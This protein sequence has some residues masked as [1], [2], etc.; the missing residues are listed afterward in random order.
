MKPA[1]FLYSRPDSIEVALERLRANDGA[2]LL[3]GGQSLVPMLNLRLATPNE[4]VD[5]GGI[6]ELRQLTVTE[7]AVLTGAMTTQRTV[8]RSAA[9]HERVPL[10][11]DALKH[12][13]HA[14]T[15]NRGTVGGSI[16]H[17]DPSAEIGTAL[18]ALDG[19]L[20]VCSAERGERWVPAEEL[21]FTYFTTTV[22][23][24]ELTIEVEFPVSPAGAGHAFVEVTRRAGDFALASA[25]VQLMLSGTVIADIRIAVGGAASTP[26]RAR[27]AEAALVG[28]ELEDVAALR[29]AAK[30]PP[31]AVRF[32]RDVHA[33]AEYRRHVTSV[34]IER[35]VRA[36]ARSA[37][38]ASARVQR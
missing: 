33:S 16:M 25:A 28:Q 13:G 27:E 31:P 3:A 1:P 24:D 8:E 36:A 15:R 12:V 20:R 9:V 19:R 23:P 35:A 38:P 5:L 37:E 30:V 14:V 32:R 18:L 4:L 21:F 2:K 26:V 11:I 29:R 34:L 22:E 17:A 10:L 6:A 7:D